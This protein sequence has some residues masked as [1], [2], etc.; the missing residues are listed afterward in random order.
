M[1]RVRFP[2]R[3]GLEI[4]LFAVGRW[5]PADRRSEEPERGHC[6]VA[7]LEELANEQGPRS[8]VGRARPW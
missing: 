1:H 2:V 5:Q 8:S 7:G 4:G 3:V 6:R